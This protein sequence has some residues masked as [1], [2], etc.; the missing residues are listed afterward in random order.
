MESGEIGNQIAAHSIQLE[1]SI[2]ILVYSAAKTTTNYL[3]IFRLSKFISFLV[4]FALFGMEC[5]NME[6]SDQDSIRRKI[7]NVY[8]TIPTLTK[9][10]FAISLCL[11]LSIILTVGSFLITGK[12]YIYRPNFWIYT[13]F[14]INGIITTPIFMCFPFLYKYTGNS[15]ITSYEV[16]N[17]FSLVFNMA[18]HYFNF[19]FAYSIGREASMEIV[20]YRYASYVPYFLLFF[21]TISFCIFVMN[22]SVI[23]NWVCLSLCLI[24]SVITLLYVRRKLISG[25][26]KLQVALHGILLGIVIQSIS[27]MLKYAGLYDWKINMVI[28]FVIIPISISTET[29]LISW[30]LKRAHQKFKRMINSG[31]FDSY[32]NSHSSSAVAQ[33]ILMNI[34][35][36][37]DYKFIN[38]SLNKYTKC[39]E[40]L[41]TEF[42]F[43]SKK[44]NINRMKSSYNNMTTLDNLTSIERMRL[45]SYKS[46]L[47]NH[48]DDENDIIIKD[49]ESYLSKYKFLIGKFWKNVVFGNSE[50]LIGISS[51]IKVSFLS[52]KTIFDLFGNEGPLKKS[53]DSF[54]ELCPIDEST[55]SRFAKSIKLQEKAYSRKEYMTRF[56]YVYMEVI[57]A[58]IIFIVFA[59]R[60]QARISE[61]KTGFRVIQNYSL[62]VEEMQGLLLLSNVIHWNMTVDKYSDIIY[63]DM[64]FPTKLKNVSY[65]A[66]YL[67]NALKSNLNETKFPFND[68]KYSSAFNS[69][70]YDSINYTT[71]SG[72]KFL[73]SIEPALVFKLI[74]TRDV[75]NGDVNSYDTNIWDNMSVNIE[76]LRIINRLIDAAKSEINDSIQSTLN[77]MIALL[78]IFIVIAIIF[79]FVYSFFTMSLN[80]KY[81]DSL[82]SLS[83]LEIKSYSESIL[84]ENQDQKDDAPKEM[85]SSRHPSEADNSFFMDKL[86]SSSYMFN[87]SW[88][89]AKAFLIVFVAL[90]VNLF[91]LATFY[92]SSKRK[93]IALNEAMSL[94]KYTYFAP[95]VLFNIGYKLVE[96]IHTNITDEIRDSYMVTLK[97][98]MDI[99]TEGFRVIPTYSSNPIDLNIY[100]DER[101]SR[102]SFLNGATNFVFS[103]IEMIYNETINITDEKVDWIIRL[104]LEGATYYIPTL[105]Q[106]LDDNLDAYSIDY[107]LYI[108]FYAVIFFVMYLLAVV[109]ISSINSAS[110][111]INDVAWQAVTTLP[112]NMW[113]DYS[114]IIDTEFERRKEQGG[115]ELYKIFEEYNILDKINT[116]TFILDKNLNIKFTSESAKQAFHDTSDGHTGESI[117]KLF[118]ES[119]KSFPKIDAIPFNSGFVQANNMKKYYNV[120]IN[121]TDQDLSVCTVRNV[122]EEFLGRKQLINDCNLIKILLSSKAEINNY[123]E[124]YDMCNNEIQHINGYFVS[125]WYIGHIK[126]VDTVIAIEKY[127]R[128]IIAGDK[129]IWINCRSA[130]TFRIYF[131]M[132][133]D[134]QHDSEINCLKVCQTLLNNLK[135]IDV[136]P[137]VY[138]SKVEEIKMVIVNGNF[139]VHEILDESHEYFLITAVLCTKSDIFVSRNF[140]ESL[141][142]SYEVEFTY[143][144][145][146][147]KETVYRLASLTGIETDSFQSSNRNSRKSM[148]LSLPFN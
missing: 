21:F 10:L 137:H 144:A 88:Y 17:L 46:R 3:S 131:H 85:F 122:T 25:Q 74:E 14:I 31:I 18:I 127:I 123:N 40:L 94:M 4:V 36:I 109:Y 129:N 96:V 130:T 145:Q 104:G 32:F 2:Y 9:S 138:L 7:E 86:R 54:T 5:L 68:F 124:G 6:D 63:D 119:M 52:L 139:L 59:A 65:D 39:F 92:A 136:V 134:E 77:L 49:C 142:N 78:V 12:K 47:T 57:I 90:I 23:T 34:D 89:V 13:V 91:A 114:D 1:S 67:Y 108:F 148:R 120:E 112:E 11:F 19:I 95:G 93:V 38:E 16:L 128:E 133:A 27:N 116:P 132:V 118:D 73:T 71:P 30:S 83:K 110:P 69:I 58:V 143:H 79:S 106:L 44:K 107:N 51:D 72:S 28:L 98:F 61:V 76:S 81:Y 140:Y 115:L 75:M 56:F 117:Q 103:I 111:T 48:N 80:K 55:N 147:G 60:N 121:K 146:F 35:Y 113:N 135:R 50:K 82:F 22:Y 141:L 102:I 101:G 125:T 29:V 126:N 42:L 70:L 20:Y 15:S 24:I 100:A 97:L 62:V 105:N 43:A 26:S 84:E 8:Q 45:F 41:E 87:F 64:I 37:D 66:D 99:L 53:Y 33:D